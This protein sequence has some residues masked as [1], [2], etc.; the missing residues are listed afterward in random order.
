MAPVRAP[1]TVTK[2]VGDE[3]QWFCVRQVS[4]ESCD[5]VLDLIFSIGRTVICAN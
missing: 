3:L 1:N 4:G 2:R 5:S